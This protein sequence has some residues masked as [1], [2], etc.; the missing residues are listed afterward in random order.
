MTDLPENV[1]QMAQ[2]N[3]I[4][5]DTHLLEPLTDDKRTIY[6]KTVQFNCYKCNK[7]FTSYY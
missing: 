6:L 5:Q 2:L 7:I 4:C 3:E 1:G